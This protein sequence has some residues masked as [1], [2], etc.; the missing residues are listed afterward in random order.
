MKLRNCEKIQLSFTRNI[1]ATTIL[2]KLKFGKKKKQLYFLYL[3]HRRK[4]KML[5]DIF[6]F[7]WLREFDAR[8]P[9]HNIKTSVF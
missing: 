6:A 2:L 3:W 8:Q 4:T 9:Q 7:C 5:E 1:N